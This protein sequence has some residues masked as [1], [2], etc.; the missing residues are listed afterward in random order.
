MKRLIALLLLT[1]SPWLAHAA[2]IEQL[3]QLTDYVGVDYAGAVENGA[4]INPGEYGEMQDFSSA[5]VEQVVELP[6]TDASRQLASWMQ[7]SFYLLMKDLPFLPN[8]KTDYQG[9]SRAIEQE[10]S[11]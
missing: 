9:I 7:P 2:N 3:I 4:I 10:M 11:G 6:P 8:G 5:I 1:A